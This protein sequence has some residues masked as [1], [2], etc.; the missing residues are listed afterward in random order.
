MYKQSKPGFSSG[1]RKW[2]N[3]DSGS[4][5]HS[6]NARILHLNLYIYFFVIVFSSYHVSYLMTRFYLKNKV[7]SL[8]NMRW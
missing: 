5:I 8:S 6:Y 1:L 2:A 7:L 3:V 4:W